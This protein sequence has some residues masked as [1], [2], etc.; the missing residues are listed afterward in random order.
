MMMARK[1]AKPLDLMS[2]CKDI[3]QWPQS[4]AGFPHDVAVGDKLIELFKDFLNQQIDNG[5]AKSTIK[6]QAD[7]LWVLGGEIIRDI[8]NDDD[9]E[10][11][12]AYTL[13]GKTL[14]LQYIG[15]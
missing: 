15:D 13:S 9:E 11:D 14:L 2:I 8:C 3:D 6:R 4:W 1:Q 12:E 7:Y 10:D 5:R